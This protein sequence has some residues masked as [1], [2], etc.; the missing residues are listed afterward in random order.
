MIHICPVLQPFWT[1]V[2]D[3]IKDITVIEIRND[4]SCLLFMILI[5]AHA[6]ED[7][8]VSFLLIAAKTIILGLWRSTHP[9]S[10]T[11]WFKEILHLK[12]MEEL[13]AGPAEM[14]SKYSI[15]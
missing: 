6:L 4:P 12:L 10:I 3:L 5:P 14:I 15:I 13:G 8:L 7:C 9:L 1:K 11:E 2:I